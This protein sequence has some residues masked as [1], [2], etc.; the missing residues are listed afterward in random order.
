MKIPALPCFA[1]F[2]LAFA[3]LLRA[4]D[5]ATLAAV[6]AADDQRIAAMIAADPVRLG[7]SLS[8]GL[9]YAH[10]NGKID[11]KAS[12]IES[13]TSRQ[14]IYL[15]MEYKTRDFTVA[16]PGIVLM[17][18]RAL[19][20]AGSQD[21]INLIDLNYLAIWRLEGGQ[22]RFLA[23]QSCRNVPNV[24]LGPPPAPAPAPVAP[25]NVKAT[26]TAP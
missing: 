8:D 7:A 15:G 25:A 26:I 6:T 17:K 24:P 9:H 16:A 5:T 14:S 19:A 20:K 22:W 18:G 23:W 10:S 21:L 13:L 11:T 4:D 1:L 3:P 2:L 12:L